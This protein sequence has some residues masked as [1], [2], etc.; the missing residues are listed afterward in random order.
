MKNKKRWNILIRRNDMRKRTI[1]IPIFILFVFPFICL[2]CFGEEEEVL[3]LSLEEC[4]LKALKNNLQVAVESFNPEIADISVTQAKEFFMPSLDVDFL[5]SETQNPPYWWLQGEDTI[6]AERNDYEVSLNQQIPTGG[7]FSLSLSSYRTDTN[8]AFQLMNPRYGSTFSFDFIQPLLKNFGPKVS[9]REIIVSRNNLDISLNQL[10]SVLSETIYS[11][12]EAYWNL[13]FSI[14]SYKVRQQSLQ[15]ARDLLAKNKKEVEVGKLA[16]IEVLN[17]QAVV[18]SREADILQAESLIKSNEDLL[19]TIIN[20]S[21]EMGLKPVKIVPGDKPEFIEREITLG[22]ALKE[23]LI[24]RPDLEMTKID[25]ETKQLNLKVARNQIL[26]EL[27]LQFTYWSP[28][29][30]GDRIIYEGDN[31]I[32]GEI[33]GKEEGS[34]K[35]ALRDALKQLYNNWTVG[36]VLSLPLSSFTTRAEYSRSKVELDQSLTKLKD[37]EQQISLEVRNAVRDIETN[38]KRFQAYRLAR[39]LAMERL[40]AEEKKLYVGLTTNYFVLQYQEELARQRSLELKS[41]VDYNL[42]WG[43]LEKAMGTS[44]EKRDI[45]LSEF[46]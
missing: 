5:R 23:A 2:P 17:A 38:A 41:I 7:S 21:G 9:R 33:I 39:E 10:E 3:S 1:S 25:I 22:E 36:L 45:K 44:L 20:L 28:G 13:V 11:V 18:A 46:R 16:P 29:L 42:A 19:K 35:D 34:G 6:I 40:E 37:L 31:P 14:E 24:K 26:P 4:V 15:L 27:N 30:S 43:R 12:Q 8:E 32:T